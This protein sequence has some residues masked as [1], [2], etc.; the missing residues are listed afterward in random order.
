MNKV[1]TSETK[2]IDN[3]E[4]SKEISAQLIANEFSKTQSIFF[5]ETTKA[6]QSIDDYMI[7]ED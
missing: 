6:L 5:E 1:K 7:G 4:E 2:K 3:T